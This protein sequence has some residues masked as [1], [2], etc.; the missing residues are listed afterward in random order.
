MKFGTIELNN[1]KIENNDG[2][3]KLYDNSYPT[4]KQINQLG[5][6]NG[7][8]Q[9]KPIDEHDQLVYRFYESAAP[10]ANLGQIGSSHNLNTTN[11][12]PRGA[13]NGAMY[14]DGGGMGFLCQDSEPQDVALT[15]PHFTWS[16][17]EISVMIMVNIKKLFSAPYQRIIY[18]SYYDNVWQSPWIG[19]QFEV[20]SS[21]HINVALGGIATLTL[22]PYL[23]P[24]I[25]QSIQLGFSFGNTQFKAYYNGKVVAQTTSANQLNIGTGEYRIGKTSGNHLEY[26]GMFIEEI[27]ICDT[28]R[29]ESWF[30]SF[31]Q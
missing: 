27:R 24:Y 15:A 20:V 26:P 17:S 16:S 13:L 22:S 21:A 30:S 23:Y 12:H 8:L 25:S 29:S 7:K 2:Y 4:G 9:R 6:S 18:K 11:W 14:S 3:L 19:W 5:S 31:F 10:F 1:C 28:E